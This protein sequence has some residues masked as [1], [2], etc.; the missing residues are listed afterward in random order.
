MPTPPPTIIEGFITDAAFV[1]QTKPIN[2][3]LL[4]DAHQIGALTPK[5]LSYFSNPEVFADPRLPSQRAV[6]W[7]ADTNAHL[8]VD[9]ASFGSFVSAVNALATPITTG[10]FKII[11]RLMYNYQPVLDHAAVE[12]ELIADADIAAIYVPGSYTQSSTIVDDLVYSSAH[13]PVTVHVPASITFSL[14]LQVGQTTQQYDLVLFTSVDA[15]LVGYNV[16]HIVKVIPPLSYPKLYS[17][18]ILNSSENVFTA[19]ANAAI[20]NYN[21]TLPLYGTQMISG[22]V[23]FNAVV[24]DGTNSVSAPFNIIYKGRVPT[25]VEIR[26]AIRAELLA[27]GV[28]DEDHWRARIPGVFIAGRFYVIPFWN[29]TFVKP[30]GPIF[31]NV[32]SYTKMATDANRILASLGN[33]DVSPYIDVLDVYYNRMTTVAIPDL[34]GISA[35]IHLS[36]IIP[37]YQ[38]FSTTEENYNYMTK[39]TQDFSSTLNTILAVDSGTLISTVYRTITENLLTFYSFTSNGYE[40]C[41]ISKLCYQTIMGNQL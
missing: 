36:T 7:V 3:V 28:A 17:T 29:D 33:G 13:P 4:P 10:F 19:A 9:N 15:F 26:A 14:T 27:S 21:A 16:S 8:V 25:L 35:P 18:P 20:L 38:D 40:I 31:P 39:A 37:D 12:A 32:L 41:V 1:D 22:T 6:N 11:D 24:T 2:A 23:E 5:A 34:S 30:D